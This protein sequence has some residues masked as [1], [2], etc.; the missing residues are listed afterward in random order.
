VGFSRGRRMEKA[1][2]ETTRDQRS[3]D[4]LSI[5]IDDSLRSDPVCVE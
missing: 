3:R 2:T 5:D 1:D 4:A